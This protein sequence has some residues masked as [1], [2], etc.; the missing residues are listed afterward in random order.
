MI[1]KEEVKLFLLTGDG[2]LYTENLRGSRTRLYNIA[3]SLYYMVEQ[4]LEIVVM[5]AAMQS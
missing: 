5:N 1:E 2:I 4:R 3:S